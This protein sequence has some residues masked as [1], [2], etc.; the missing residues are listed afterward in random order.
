M[1]VRHI[2]CIIYETD[3]HI[4]GPEFLLFSPGLTKHDVLLFFFVLGKMDVRLLF[5]VNRIFFGNSMDSGDNILGRYKQQ[6]TNCAY[7]IFHFTPLVDE[8]Y[9]KV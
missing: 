5:I 3:V 9:R 2:L 7:S 4:R 8:S 6:I 1:I